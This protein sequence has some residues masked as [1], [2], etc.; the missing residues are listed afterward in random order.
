MSRILSTNVH[1]DLRASGIQLLTQCQSPD[2]IMITTVEWL[3]TAALPVANNLIGRYGAP[4][5]KVLKVTWDLRGR[6]AGI[7]IRRRRDRQIRLNQQLL[8]IDEAQAHIIDTAL[9]ELA[10]ICVFQINHRLPPHGALWKECASYLGAEPGRCHRLPLKR[11]RKSREFRYLTVAGEIW[12]GAVRHRRLQSGNQ[13]YFMRDTT[14]TE[15]RACD[16]TG[17]ERIRKD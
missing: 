5:I 6:S 9:H 7:A 2:S 11:S 16:H 13:R 17:H 12:L 3:H 15:I 8:E 1:S 4:E 14:R 10:H